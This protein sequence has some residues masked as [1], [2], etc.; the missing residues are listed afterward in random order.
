M[1]VLLN[2]LSNLFQT[3]V[4][5]LQCREGIRLPI[6]DRFEFAEIFGH[7]FAEDVTLDLLLSAKFDMFF[8]FMFWV[9]WFDD[10][11]WISGFFSHAQVTI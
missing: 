2:E 5:D 6:H 7:E 11:L 8:K 9:I 10:S 4:P 1:L 3:H